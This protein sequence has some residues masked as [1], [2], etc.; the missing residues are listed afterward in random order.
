[1]PII[2]NGHST[3]YIKRQ[4]K[5][6][7]KE[8]GITH[9]QALN[10]AAQNAG[11]FNWQH[12][13]N[14]K[15]KNP[16]LGITKQIPHPLV[17]RFR[18]AL[19]SPSSKPNARMPV[20]AHQQ[21]ATLL[22]EVS[23]FTSD[24]RSIEK[25]VRSVRCELDDWVQKEHKTEEEMSS[26]VF[27]NMYYG[28]LTVRPDAEQR[29]HLIARL[30]RVASI[31]SE[32]YHDCPPL[33]S[34]HRKLEMAKRAISRWL[35]LPI[36]AQ[37]T[38]YRYPRPVKSGTLIRL[39]RSG[40]HAIVYDSLAGNGY[41]VSCY[42]HGGSYILDRESFTVPKD[43]S[44]AANFIPMRLVLPYGK[45]TCADGTEVLFNRDY[46]PLWY[47][48]PN[49]KVGTLDPDTWVSWKGSSHYFNDGQVPWHK[50]RQAKADECFA[51]LKEWGVDTQRPKIL[52]WWAKAM[53]DGNMAPLDKKNTSK[54]FPTSA[55]A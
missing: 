9:I 5:K 32:H 16:S 29:N 19:G 2:R 7:G 47:K 41:G 51:V 42:G 44:G 15:G 55:A 43:Q 26:E 23:Y 36:K 31:L 10:L 35:E 50:K 4:A 8:M 18:M 53:Q 46:S 33:R 30:D 54:R 21:I 13:I 37:P 25:H 52:D 40:E 27:H 1:M 6:I 38:R 17:L 24:R 39:K 20:S 14:A 11:F 28:S 45:W 48:S 12:C 34:L 49:G 3:D 22:K